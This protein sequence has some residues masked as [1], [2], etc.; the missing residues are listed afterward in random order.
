M[1]RLA[2]QAMTGRPWAGGAAGGTGNGK[3]TVKIPP[4]LP[5]SG[6]G[7]ILLDKTASIAHHID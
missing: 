3:S 6:P 7:R 4:N 1:I 2:G 5:Q